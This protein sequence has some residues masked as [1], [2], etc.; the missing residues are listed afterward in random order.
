MNAQAQIDALDVKKFFKVNSR[1]TYYSNVQGGS[2]SPTRIELSSI[3][4]N[5]QPGTILKVKTLGGYSCC[6]NFDPSQDPDDASFNVTVVFVNASGG[7]IYPGPRS[8][9]Y[10]AFNSSLPYDILEDV[11]LNQ[12]LQSLEVPAGAVA[13]LTAPDDFYFLDNNDAN[14]N[15]GIEF[16]FSIIDKIDIYQVVKNPILNTKSTT[17]DLVAGKNADIVV[18]T[19]PNLNVEGS[20]IE[21]KSPNGLLTKTFNVKSGQTSSTAS[22][23]VTFYID[24]VPTESA[25]LN[26]GS[27]P[28]VHLRGKNSSGVVVDIDE[29]GQ[30]DL[31]VRPHKTKDIK[32]NFTALVGCTDDK[33]AP[34]FAPTTDQQVN[35][36]ITYGVPLT[37]AMFPVR[38][39][40]ISYS[41]EKSSKVLGRNSLPVILLPELSVFDGDLFTIDKNYFLNL[42]GLSLTNKINYTVG[43]GTKEYFLY[44]E[45]KD[46]V[47][48]AYEIPGANP[49]MPLKVNSILVNEG[50]YYT[51][52]HELGHMNGLIHS[53]EDTTSQCPYNKILDSYSNS[54]Q[55]QNISSFDITR[56][57]ILSTGE[58]VGV[59]LMRSSTGF[60]GFN[61]RIQPNPDYNKSF[62]KK[63]MSFDEYIKVF[64][65]LIDDNKKEIRVLTPKLHITGIFDQNSLKLFNTYKYNDNS[66]NVLSFGDLLVKTK[67]INNNEL[68]SIF[69]KK[70]SASESKNQIVSFDL[71]WNENAF[72][73]EI[74][75]SVTGVSLSKFIIPTKL[76]E[77]EIKYIDRSMVKSGI[78]YY[79]LLKL[80]TDKIQMAE[81]AILNK[82]YGSAITYLNDFIGLINYGLTNSQA[83]GNSDSVLV[84]KSKFLRIADESKINIV[85][86]LNSTGLAQNIFIDFKLSQERKV[87]KKT[88][89]E[90]IFP[91]KPD[92]QTMIFS[93]EGRLNDVKVDFIE[94]STLKYF[95][96]TIQTIGQNV[97][98]LRPYLIVK[99]EYETVKAAVL[100]YNSE[101]IRLRSELFNEPDL[102]VKQEIQNQINQRQRYI[103]GLNSSIENKKIYLGTEVQ[104]EFEGVN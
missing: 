72:F 76:I 12:N 80:M 86:A 98:K 43:L 59:E 58:T 2:E 74:L 75:D 25:F 44:R 33:S 27:S 51:L 5:I 85:N 65:N 50:F 28:I 23:D 70:A 97:W 31:Q 104:I 100:K 102:I 62:D 15:F 3:A 87:H 41:K 35:D 37:N 91:K 78:D 57:E 9:A 10:P 21:W 46:T 96:A 54:I 13:I 103:D 61:P 29:S 1:G 26:M 22:G 49:V 81:S 45:S 40:G 14:G 52:P 47:G 88:R 39:G 56:G 94:N 90:I 16:G 19:L 95:E 17:I 84:D 7:Y 48:W 79:L 53:C 92:N 32:L 20:Y 71:N 63:W 82:S 11:V 24:P 66:P 8:T 99:K 93:A 101:I 69:T 77:E 30:S 89:V 64:K 73:G 36:M 60:W 34:C 42:V 38:E 83:K 55:L 68:Q 4:G 18:K 6:G 67:T